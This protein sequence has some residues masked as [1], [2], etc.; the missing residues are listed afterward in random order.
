ML[1]PSRS[2]PTLPADVPRA[3]ARRHDLLAGGATSRAIT[4]AV[5]DGRLIRPRRDRYLPGDCDPVV[6]EAVRLGGR[7]DCTSLLRL[8]GVFVLDDT[9]SHVRLP[10][11]ASRVATPRDG[12][13][14]HWVDSAAP[15]EATV[16]PVIEALVHAVLCQPPRAAIATLDSAWHLRLV[17]ENEIAEIFRLLPRRFRRLRPL[18]DPRAEAGTE[19]L[20][21]LM[22]R[23]L[24]VVPELQVEIAGV[25]FVDFLVDGW[26]IIECDSTAHHS[27]WAARRRDIR[28]DAAAIRLGY[29]PL[30]LLAEDIL[31]HPEEVVALL[32]E[33]LGLAAKRRPRS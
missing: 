5:H 33:V 9:R 24:G 30:R 10:P 16:V 23:G 27:D 32:R 1:R 28:R 26:L 19:S 12:V 3:V 14:R 7:V 11:H 25:G 21:R 2:A 31:F 8:Y 22:L 13:V 6:A 4:A 18:L 15:T 29:V 20:V 17:D